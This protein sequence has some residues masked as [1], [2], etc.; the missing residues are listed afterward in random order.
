MQEILTR[1]YC[2]NPRCRSKL[3]E[4]VDNPHA[5]FC[6]RG[7]WLQ[8]HRSRCAVCEGEFERKNKAQ[9][10]YLCGRRKC[11]NENKQFPHLF[12]PFGRPGYQEPNGAIAKKEKAGRP[13]RATA[14]RTIDAGRGG[15]SG[16]AG[17][18]G[19]EQAAGPESISAALPTSGR[20]PGGGTSTQ[21]EPADPDDW[22]DMP[23]I[24][25]LLKR[26]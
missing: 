1:T 22:G 4:P 3:R 10:Q 24:P 16:P 12:T 18:R 9:H 8:Y 26:K 14:A 20:P 5:A 2:R 17:R 15:A 7:C 23:D 25:D 13:H 19:R 6:C 21:W 11:A